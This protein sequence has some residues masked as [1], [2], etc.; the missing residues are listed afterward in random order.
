MSILELYPYDLLTSHPSRLMAGLGLWSSLHHLSTGNV[1]VL[2]VADNLRT[3]D[4][5]RGFDHVAVPLAQ[6]EQ[7]MSQAAGK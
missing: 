4:V 1:R 3:E 5:V 6:L 7:A 2:L